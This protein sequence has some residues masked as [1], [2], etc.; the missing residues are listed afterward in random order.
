ML[1]LKNQAICP[2]P[3]CEAVCF[4]DRDEDGKATLETARCHVD[5][6]ETRMCDLCEVKCFACDCVTCPEHLVDLGGER[7]C[8]G[9]YLELVEEG[10]MQLQEAL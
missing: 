2:N 4:V 7:Y 1:L 10:E 6:C 9:C 3:D 5:G 8:V